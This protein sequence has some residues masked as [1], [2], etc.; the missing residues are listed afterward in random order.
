MRLALF[1]PDNPRNAGGAIRLCACL[2]VGLDIIRPA[3]FPLDHRDVRRTALDYGPL[4][5]VVLHDGWGGFLDRAGQ[6]RIVLLTTRG[7]ESL[8]RFSF[9]DDDIVLV[10]RESAGVPDAVHARADARVYIPLVSGARSLNVVVA[11]AMALGAAGAQ[12]RR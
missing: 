8:D 7:A 5:E 1:Q 12:L 9:R 11:A 6:A 2:G 10:G 4:A 3:G